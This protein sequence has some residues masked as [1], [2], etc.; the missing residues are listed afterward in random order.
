MDDGSSSGIAPHASD[1]PR[2]IQDFAITSSTIT[3]EPNLP[4]AG[5]AVT[6]WIEHTYDADLALELVAPD[7]TIVPLSIHNGGAEDN[8]AG[9]TFDDEADAPIQQGAAPFVGRFRPQSPLSALAGHGSHGAWTLRVTDSA[10]ADTGTLRA[11][12]LSLTAAQPQCV[13]CQPQGGPPSEVQNVR[14]TAGM[15][16]RLAWDPA[17]GAGWYN[18]YEGEG[19]DLAA[20]VTPALD[21]CL[22]WTGTATA[23]EPILLVPPRQSQLVWYLVRAGNAAGEGPAGLADGGPRQLNSGGHCP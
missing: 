9:T 12:S 1:V 22:R 16:T 18:V 10:G 19:A 7:A 14:W 4:L 20:L 3:V 5:A 23:T 15:K 8:Y 13:A 2:P 6:V 11:W 17:A 21:S